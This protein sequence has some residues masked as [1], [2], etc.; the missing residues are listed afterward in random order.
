MRYETPLTKNCCASIDSL[1]DSH[2][3]SFTRDSIED[4]QTRLTESPGF[5]N[6]IVR[7]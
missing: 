3:Y 1:T 5:G 4:S 6:L 7:E 2:T